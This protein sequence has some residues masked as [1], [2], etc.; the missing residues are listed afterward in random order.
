MPG[1]DP[2]HLLLVVAA[3][4]EAQALIAG[5]G[6]R[7]GEIRPWA[8]V[9][10]TDRVDLVLGGI[11]KVNAAGAVLLA[12]DPGR[13]RTVLSVGVGGAL[14]GACLPIGACV[15]ATESVYADEGI[16]TPGGFRTTDALGFPLGPFQHGRLPTDPGLLELLRPGV[17]ADARVATVSCCSGTDEGAREVVCRTGAA[18]EAMEGAAMA[19]AVR[20]RWP[21]GSVRAGEV[22]VVSNTTGDRD[23][24]IWSLDDALD[25]LREWGRWA[26]GVPG[27]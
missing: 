1:T 18:L 19:H 8:P 14:P 10:V 2:A 27:W 20:R 25:R 24:Q 22:R 3:P 13:H 15:S 9:P 21:E 5:L 6:G 7:S 12:L 16:A 11:G 4:K 17:D 23:R 26:S